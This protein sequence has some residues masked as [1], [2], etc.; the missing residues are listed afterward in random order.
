MWQ[1]RGSV[2]SLQAARFLPLPLATLLIVVVAGCGQSDEPSSS[3][4]D[5][6]SAAAS[7]GPAAVNSPTQRDM[8]HPVL[9]I[10]TNMGPIIVRLDAETASVTVQNF[11]N[12]VDSGFYKNTIFHY[13]AP[14]NMILGGGYSIDRELKPHREPILNEARSGRKNLRGTIAMARDTNLVDSASSQFFIN[15]VDAPQRDYR[16]DAPGDYGYCVFGEVIDGLNVAERIARAP[17]ADLSQMNENLSNTPNPPV[18]IISM[19]RVDM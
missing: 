15:L 6:L 8:K 2:K 10:D 14:D 1:T 5:G 18:V 4:G 12:Y 13:V 11:L 17:A 7:G 16:G 3:G 9:R 19:T